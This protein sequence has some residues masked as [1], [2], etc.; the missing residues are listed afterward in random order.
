MET[1]G[2]LAARIKRLKFSLFPIVKPFDA[3]RAAGNSGLLA[4]E[5]GDRG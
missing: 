3:G 1:G 4:G 5:A 2:S